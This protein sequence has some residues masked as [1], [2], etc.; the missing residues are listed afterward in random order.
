MSLKYKGESTGR[1]P[2]RVPAFLPGVCT[3]V[4]IPLL[5]SPPA[6]LGTEPLFPP[7][8]VEIPLLPK[9]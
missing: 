3:A 1:L 8:P 7:L 2:A 5:C 9:C 4:G 6:I